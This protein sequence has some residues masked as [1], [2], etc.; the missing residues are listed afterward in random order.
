MIEQQTFLELGVNAIH[1]FQ[2]RLKQEAYLVGQAMVYVLTWPGRFAKWLINSLGVA[3]LATLGASLTRQGHHLMKWRLQRRA[4]QT[5][6]AWNNLIFK[7]HN[8]ALRREVLQLMREHKYQAHEIQT[9]HERLEM[10]RTKKSLLE[11]LLADLLEES[12]EQNHE[13]SEHDLR[14]AYEEEY[15]RAK[16]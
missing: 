1:S 11:D 4:A 16:V 13:Q 2:L 14:R 8:R 10:L 7:L 9:L 15:R 6:E 5:Q 3:V 12:I